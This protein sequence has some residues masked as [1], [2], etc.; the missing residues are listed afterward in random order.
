M[1]SEMNLKMHLSQRKRYLQESN[2]ENNKI[3]EITCKVNF[4][5][6]FATF[7]H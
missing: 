1:S 2:T 6:F 4:M 7:M 5:T 3:E